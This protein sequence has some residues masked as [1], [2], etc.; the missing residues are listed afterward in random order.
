MAITIGAFFG[1]MLAGVPIALCLCLGAL[2][3]MA[4]TGN[5]GLNRDYLINTVRELE[6]HGY[7]DIEHHELLTR[8]QHRTG[9]IDQG[10]GI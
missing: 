6:A 5:M 10:G 3:Y 1:I 2:I 9:L 7:Q 4:A 8:V